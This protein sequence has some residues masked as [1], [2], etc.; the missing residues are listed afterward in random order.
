MLPLHYVTNLPSAGC[1]GGIAVITGNGSNIVNNKRQC[2][3]Y[4]KKPK[5][6]SLSWDGHLS[7]I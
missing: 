3:D 7:L 5:L 1:G 6:D 4:L 2:Y